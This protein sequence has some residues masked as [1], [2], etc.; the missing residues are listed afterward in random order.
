MTLFFPPTII[1][2]TNPILF[3]L[4]CKKR[5]RNKMF[6]TT[7][8]GLKPKKT[9]CFCDFLVCGDIRIICP[10]KTLLWSASYNHF[11]WWS[12]IEMKHEFCLNLPLSTPLPLLLNQNCYKTYLATENMMKMYAGYFMTKKRNWKK[13]NK[14]NTAFHENPAYWRHWIS[15]CVRIPEP[16]SYLVFIQPKKQDFCCYYE[17]NKYLYFFYQFLDVL[18]FRTNF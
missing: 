9:H 15:Q 17:L 16:E 3:G 1:F 13:L 2:K 14:N 12:D 8:W 10:I 7:E 4:V 5:I 6:G 11:S 18:V